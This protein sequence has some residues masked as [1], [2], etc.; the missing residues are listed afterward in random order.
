MPS[1]IEK[2]RD[3]VLTSNRL[4][5]IILDM[6]SNYF[7]KVIADAQPGDRIT[8]SIHACA[9][10]AS[11]LSAWIASGQIYESGGDY[12]YRGKDMPQGVT[13]LSPSEAKALITRGLN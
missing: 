8:G 11:T 1:P 12:R 6:S 4:L 13:Q 2:D 5:T 7:R 10:P 3:F 9:V